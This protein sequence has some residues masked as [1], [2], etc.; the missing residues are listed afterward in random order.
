MTNDNNETD[1]LKI[2]FNNYFEALKSLK[3]LGVVPNSKDFTSQLGE[4][5]V[6]T[7][8][9]GEK[10]IS[11]IQKDWDINVNGK[12]FQVKTHA[13][14]TTTS[15]R[16]T[17]IKYR[18]NAIIDELVIIVFSAE[19]KLKEYYSVPWPDALGHIRQNESGH[20]IYWDHLIKYKKA[21]GS[22][23]KQHIISVFI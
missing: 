21:I 16:W 23:P 6:T 9:D 11:G 10:A 8:F 2:A 19:Y 13:K 1:S 14:A 5:L 18:P 20:V 12:L 22:L 4:W 15:A 17:S 7:L 3:R